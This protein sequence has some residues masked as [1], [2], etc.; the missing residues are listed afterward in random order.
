M[1]KGENSNAFLYGKG[2]F[3]TV[4]IVGGEPFLW[5]KHWRR[6]SENA[7]RSGIDIAHISERSVIEAARAEDIA[8]GR[9]RITIAD[10]SSAEIWRTE[11]SENK[12][13]FSII[14]GPLRKLPE[15]FQL[16]V[17]PV[18][19]NST[20]PLAGIKSTNYLEQLFALKEARNRGFHEA[21][22]VNER[23]R[24]VSGC[25]ANLFWLK[26][27]RL[28][29]P[30]AETGCLPGTTREFILENFECEEAA[31]EIETI[32]KADAL[33][34]SSAGLGV[35]RVAELDGRKFVGTKHPI[36]DILKHEKPG[37]DPR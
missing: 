12:A 5:E 8:E 15:L 28:F 31:V 3:T 14:S 33:F 32:R 29:T 16:T 9:V 20:S 34:L 13:G 18:L 1:N 11:T 26:A 21:V 22:R 36:E 19:V 37:S 30:P 7:E 2:V 23:G 4:R 24:A 10:N 6:L 25:M 27:G 17:S 35:V